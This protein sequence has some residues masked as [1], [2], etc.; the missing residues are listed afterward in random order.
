L[1]GF[2]LNAPDV[3]YNNNCVTFYNHY[4]VAAH[5]NQHPKPPDIIIYIFWISIGLLNKT[6]FYLFT[7]MYVQP[8]HHSIQLA[9][10]NDPIISGLF[11][12]VSYMII[13]NIMV[14]RISSEASVI[15]PFF[16]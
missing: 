3:A 8:D 10:I 13:H 12:F 4:Q 1:Y 15:T 9:S 16:I 11:S 5:K 14:I 6:S 2:V 7:N